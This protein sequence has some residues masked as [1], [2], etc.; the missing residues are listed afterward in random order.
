MNASLRSILK[1]GQPLVISY[2][3]GVDST[4]MLVGLWLEGIR[5]D[6]ILFADTGS[7]KEETY[8]DLVT[9]NAW[10]RS[11]GFPE[12]T[13]V[14]YVPKKFKWNKYST[15]EGNCISNRTLPS[16]A[17][18][19]KG[20]S[21]KWKAAPMDKFVTETYGDALVYRA[22]GYDC[23]P[24]DNKRFAHAQGKTAG[25]KGD[26]FIYPLQVWGWH[27][28]ECA[29]QIALAGL[30]VPPK[31]SCFFCPAMKAAEV[32]ALPV[33]KL[34]R[35]VIMEANASINLD[36]VV[37]LWRSKRMTDHIR[38]K[39]LLPSEDIDALWTKWSSPSRLITIK[40]VASEDVILEEA[41]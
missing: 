14:R 6:A 5:P 4:A 31:S 7:E 18:G 13:V 21:L 34:R 2:G 38:A 20:C 16:L 27:R 24:A 15:I 10:L 39:G 1:P 9:I 3:L 30:P 25:R 33:D 28:I 12:I 37:G 11:V 35:I 19:M 26:M 17:F 36:T 41:A 8:D 23:S 29:R 32:E 40:E 22:I